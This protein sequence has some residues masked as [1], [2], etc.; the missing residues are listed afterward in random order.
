MV[1]HSL[2]FRFNPEVVQLLYVGLMTHAAC[3]LR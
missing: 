2:I 1:V 3:M